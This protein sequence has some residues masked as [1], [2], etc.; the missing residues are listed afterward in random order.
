[1]SLF[2]GSMMRIFLCEI[3]CNYMQY[4]YCTC[5][6]SRLHHTR[7]IGSIPSLLHTMIL[8]CW[9]RSKFLCCW[10]AVCFHSK[11]I[12]F[13]CMITKWFFVITFE[14]YKWINILS[15]CQMVS[16]GFCSGSTAA[17]RRSFR[18][19]WGCSHESLSADSWLPHALQREEKISDVAVWLSDL[20]N[21]AVSCPTSAKQGRQ[22]LLGT[23]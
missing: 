20:G 13:K 23:V 15:D 6:N 18:A 1:M 16:K 14:I 21:R 8:N 3:N 10:L 11:W 22:R 2:I 17:C 9:Y 4:L 7:Y 5:D 12:T 19:S